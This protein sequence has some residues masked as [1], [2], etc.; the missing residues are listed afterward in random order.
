MV[1]TKP[2]KYIQDFIDQIQIHLPTTF[3]LPSFL[4]QS[5]FHLSKVSKLFLKSFYDIAINAPPPKY[6]IVSQTRCL[7]NA[8]FPRG[9]VYESV[10]SEE[11]K[12]H[13]VQLDKMVTQVKLVVGLRTYQIYFVLPV[14]SKIAIP[15][16]L[17]MM[18]MWLHIVAKFAGD[19]CS[20]NVDVYL[21]LTDLK[22]LLPATQRQ[23]I[24]LEHVN[25]AFTTG[26]SDRTEIFIFRK[27]E[28]FK[29][30]VHECFHN[31][32]LDFDIA[33]SKSKLVLQS[34][35]QLQSNCHLEESYCE[36]WAETINILLI[37]AA[38]KKSFEECLPVIERQIHQERIFSLFQA[39]KVLN[40]FGLG[41]RD[42]IDKTPEKGDLR[43]N[44]KETTEAFCYFVLKS[45]LMFN[46]NEFIEWMFLNCKSIKFKE[47][48]LNK[49]VNDLIVQKHNEM[50]F[51]RSLNGIQTFFETSRR[52][53]FLTST[54]RMS[55][56]ELEI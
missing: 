23:T 50:K 29:V 31:M 53:S 26:C 34:I 44:Y 54:L 49:F 9:E 42:V 15:K 47:N 5:S 43:S 7:P 48:Q 4:L 39:A 21:Y 45:I 17:F 37:N 41:Y 33:K 8:P 1:F 40:H 20:K 46:F 28:W 32:G 16:C 18:N 11:I 12:Q 51:M 55:A 56:L 14:G 24:E 52:K 35:F 36:M 38:T 2:S 27:E 6:E 30:F 13:I 25:T 3:H 22:K 10:D 19:V